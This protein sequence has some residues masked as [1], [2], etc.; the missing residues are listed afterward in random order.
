M[1]GFVFF[2]FIDPGE[3]EGTK[4][5]VANTETPAK[6]PTT[7]KPATNTQKASGSTKT[8]DNATNKSTAASTNKT[9]QT[10]KSTSSTAASTKRTQ[11]KVTP[12]QSANA[13]EIVQVTDKLGRSYVIV[14]SFIDQDLAMDYAKVL[15][16][17]GNGVKIIH[18]FGKVKRY[19]VSIAD[20]GT[21]AD[22]SGQLNTYKSSFGD[23]VWALK[24]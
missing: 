7:K 11:R 16:S 2:W 18:P 17:Q 23:Q 15:S 21:Y 8:T 10:R 9:S 20:F 4:K 1:I 3:G 22:A 12:A 5:A 19:R 6:K 24:Y 13:G 14:G